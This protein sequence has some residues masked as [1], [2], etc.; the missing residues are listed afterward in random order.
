MKRRTVEQ[1]EKMIKELPFVNVNCLLHEEECHCERYNTELKVIGK[2]FCDQLFEVERDSAYLSPKER[3][4]LRKEK[5]IP[6][7]TNFWNWIEQTN[8]LKNSI[9]G[10]ALQYAKNQKVYLM[11]YLEE[12][13]CQ[14]SNN[15]AERST[16]PF[17]VGRKA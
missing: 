11:N 15:L 3:I 1:K 8:A 14:L 16:R 2:D 7:L 17:V 13:K 9:L 10:K 4:N 6:I 12:G 5:L